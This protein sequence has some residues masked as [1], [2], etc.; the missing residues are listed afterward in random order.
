MALKRCE[1]GHYYESSQFGACPH[2]GHAD[3]Y[4]QPT[5]PKRLT[6]PEDVAPAESAEAGSAATLARAQTAQHGANEGRTIGIFQKSL[7][8]DP[9]VGWLVC[10][11][12][13]ARGRDFRI[14]SG[15]NFIG[16]GE[17]MDIR[18]E[19]DAAI[20]REKHAVISYDPKRANFR[21]LPGDGAGLTY[22]NDETVD[23]AAELKPFDIIELGETTLWFVPFCGK[24][25]RWRTEPER[26]DVWPPAAGSP[27][28]RR[29]SRSGAGDEDRA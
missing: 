2:C 3:L 17:K 7:G 8:I 6:P 19:G 29:D 1:D 16:R 24:H 21:L 14:R 22:L 23:A 26:T 10:V 28:V 4:A 18:I 9:V 11:E 5:V 20:S 15:R 12:G 25:F 27:P 13:P